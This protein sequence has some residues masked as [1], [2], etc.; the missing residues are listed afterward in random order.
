LQSW[1]VV[2]IFYAIVAF[3]A[4]LL[5]LGAGRAKTVAVEVHHAAQR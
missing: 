4:L 1:P 3:L 5:G 2:A